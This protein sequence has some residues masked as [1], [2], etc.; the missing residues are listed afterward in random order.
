MRYLLTLFLA[1]STLPL[2][3]ASPQRERRISS[4][5]KPLRD[6]LVS[7]WAMDEASGNALDLMGNCPL[8]NYNTAPRVTGFVNNAMSGW[9]GTTNAYL[10]TISTKLNFAH[11]FSISAWVLFNLGAFRQA[12]WVAYND[13]TDRYQ[14][15]CWFYGESTRK[16]AF[17]TSPDGTGPSVEYLY[18]RSDYTLTSNLWQHVVCTWDGVEKRL[19][20]NNQKTNYPCSAVF[21]NTN[22]FHIGSSHVSTTRTYGWRGGI[23]EVGFWNRA[24][25]DSEVARLYANGHGRLYPF[26]SD[27]PTNPPRFDYYTA[28]NASTF[29]TLP[30]YDGA[31]QVVHPD[32]VHLSTNWN[33]YPFWM[34]MTPYKNGSETNENPS[35]LC[36]SDGTTWSVPAGL[37]NPIVQYPGA[38]NHYSDTDLL[39]WTNGTAYLF[40]SYYTTNLDSVLLRSSTYGT[41]WSGESTMFSLPRTSTFTVASPTVVWNGSECVMI[42]T[43]TNRV[44]HRRTSSDPSGPWSAATEL[45]MPTLASSHAYWHQDMYYDG[46][47]YYLLEH[48][49]TVAQSFFF[50]RSTNSINWEDVSRGVLLTGVAGHWDNEVYRGTF[51]ASGD[52]FDLWY[53]GISNS[54]YKVGRSFIR[55]L[56]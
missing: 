29:L 21:Y 12:I 10:G 41:N 1:L 24:L 8:T 11:P 44:I 37:T 3:A 39:I 5:Q 53:G 35:I 4:A 42:Y 19:Y 47:Y 43:S 23:D 50:L 48:S 33:G 2:F 40:Y 15:F 32:V 17:G 55:R 27:N 14:G 54:V 18:N 26:T 45:T 6:G 34:A 7:Y 52:G 31:N 13:V 49:D 28:T 36:S 16:V 9:D 56:P 25:S 22:T 20:I 46:S 51:T 30:T 38:T